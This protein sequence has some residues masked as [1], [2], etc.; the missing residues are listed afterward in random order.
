MSLSAHP[1]LDRAG[2]ALP[3]AIG[4]LSAL[5]VL[6]MGLLI[7]VDLNAKTG[8]N[9][10]SAVRA[11]QVAEAGASHTLALLRGSLVATSYTNLLRGSDGAA[12]TADDGVLSGFGL[13]AADAIPDTGRTMAQGRYLITLVDDPAD[14]VAAAATDGN[15]RIL[16]RCRGITPDGGSAEIRMTIGSTPF[17][18]VV[19]DGTLLV[20]GNPKVYGACGSIH[21]N[22]IV[23]VSGNPNVS[24]GITA[25][26]TV[27]VSGH[28]ED[29]TGNTIKPLSNQ[30]PIE[31]PHLEPADYCDDADYVLHAD[32]KFETVGPPNVIQNAYGN[33]I[34]GWKLASTSPVKWDVSGSSMAAGTYCVTGNV[35]I[36]GNPAGPSGTDLP[37]S[38]L[39]TGSVEFSGNPQIAPDHPDGIAVIA[40]G[41]ISLSGNPSSLGY[42]GVFYS[43]SQCM[44]SGNPTIIG[45]VI[46]DD[47]PNASGTENLVSENKLNG[48]PTITYNCGGMFGGVRRVLSWF[49]QLGT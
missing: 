9:R 16:A 45:Q 36:S 44:I 22:Q 30:P 21:A 34:N 49:Q 48:D 23:V 17:P 41:D 18:G 4:A 25:S 12:S 2:I 15:N 33:E 42:E 6:L 26:D 13:P 3:A 29:S 1:K 40:G 24:V 43:R 10:R 8:I 38:I 39:A 27:K 37:L 31:I 47:E 32:G 11:L 46:C 19:T 7:I 20:D 35:K 28:V 14:P 5:A